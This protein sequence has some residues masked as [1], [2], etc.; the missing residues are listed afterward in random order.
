MDPAGSQDP[1][2]GLQPGPYVR[3]AW[4][5]QKSEHY[6]EL[7]KEEAYDVIKQVNQIKRKHFQADKATGDLANKDVDV[8]PDGKPLD[9]FTATQLVQQKVKARKAKEKAVNHTAT[10]P[11]AV[12]DAFDA[13]GIRPP[14]SSSSSVFGIA[15][16]R[17][18]RTSPTTWTRCESPTWSLRWIY[19]PI[20][21]KF[22]EVTYVLDKFIILDKTYMMLVFDWSRA[23]CSVTRVVRRRCSLGLPT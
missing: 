7:N 1:A 11:E 23:T 13:L 9:V 2:G 5:E 6:P 10:A 16:T 15:T 22:L 19:I 18:T 12:R 8:G 17:T 20:I 4:K 21:E 14:S 3:Q